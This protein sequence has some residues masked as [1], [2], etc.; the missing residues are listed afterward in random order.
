MR[1]KIGYWLIKPIPKTDI[2]ERGRRKRSYGM[3]KRS[4]KDGMR[5]IRRE[6]FVTLCNFLG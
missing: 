6:G 3:I 4:M 5:D 1:K 2:S